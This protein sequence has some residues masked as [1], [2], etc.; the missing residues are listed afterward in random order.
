MVV[1]VPFAALPTKGTIA[2]KE[3][4]ST[5]MGQRQKTPFEDAAERVSRAYREVPNAG[6]AIVVAVALV[7]GV[8]LLE[9]HSSSSQLTRTRR[10]TSCCCSGGAVVA[11]AHTMQGL[12]HDHKGDRDRE[13]NCVDGVVV[14][15][16]ISVGVVLVEVV[17]AMDCDPCP[18]V[19]TSTNRARC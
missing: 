13:G 4:N 14:G 16:M 12:R 9:H 2:R 3:K 10:R 15:A 7:R 11:V 19:S 17:V 1:D 6:H 5:M 8:V 18:L